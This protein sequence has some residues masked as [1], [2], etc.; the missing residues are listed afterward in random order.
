MSVREVKCIFI[1]CCLHQDLVT[2]LETQE[3]QADAVLKEVGLIS[4]VASPQVLESL[5]VDCSRLKE[6]IS[7]TKDMIYLKREERDKGLLK[8]LKG[9]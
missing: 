5:C 9:L 4:S 3:Q 8:V 1:I 2:D 7:R 6:A